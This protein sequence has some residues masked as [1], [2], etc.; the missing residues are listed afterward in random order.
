[1][2]TTYV[3]V[4]MVLPLVVSV[5]ESKTVTFLAVHQTLMLYAIELEETSALV[6]PIDLNGL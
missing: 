3:H 5:M 4:L 2:N 6:S 1:M